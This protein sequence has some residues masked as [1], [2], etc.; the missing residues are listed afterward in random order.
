[1][2][3]GSQQSALERETCKGHFVKPNCSRQLRLAPL[4]EQHLCRHF[5]TGSTHGGGAAA[6]PAAAGGGGGGGQAFRTQVSRFRS[7]MTMALLDGS[8]GCLT[9]TWLWD[10]SPVARKTTKSLGRSGYRTE[11]HVQRSQEVEVGRQEH[12][13]R[14]QEEAAAL[15]CRCPGAEQGLRLHDESGRPALSQ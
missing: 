13:T 11:A 2:R 9:T 6:A 5:G 7:Y 10:S 14:R 15:P 12:Q 8:R 3:L 1:M 4:W